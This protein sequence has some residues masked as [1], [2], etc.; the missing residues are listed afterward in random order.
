ME[1]GN[2]VQ[3]SFYPSVQLYITLQQLLFIS[4]SHEGS[5]MAAGYLSFQFL[6]LGVLVLGF[7]PL[8][9]HPCQAG[10]HEAFSALVEK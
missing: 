1:L 2:K 9:R 7:F 8:M 10:I 3:R 6:F 4:H 5:L